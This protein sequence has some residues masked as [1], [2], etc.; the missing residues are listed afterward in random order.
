VAEEQAVAGSGGRRG[1]RR[2]RRQPGGRPHAVKVLLSDAERE[3]IT[4]RAAELG[5][6][7]PRLLVEA[8]LA[9]GTRQTVS[10]RHGLLA[11]F[12]GAR[13]LVAKVSNNLN[14]LTAAMHSTGEVGPQLEATLHA[15]ART[16][17]RLERAAEVL[18]R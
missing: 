12:T 6:S 18:G 17:A 7:V 15:A 5:V 4:A 1:P 10:E 8:A 9:D 16:L 13:R 11:E 3:R 14:Q 2:L